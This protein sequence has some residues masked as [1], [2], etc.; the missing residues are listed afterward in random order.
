MVNCPVCGM[1][2]VQG[3]PEDEKA[4]R[5]YHDPI[6]NGKPGRPIKSDKVVWKGLGDRITVVTGHSP[7]PQRR[8]AEKAGQVANAEMHYDRGIY[9]AT[10]PPDDRDIHLFLYYV[11]NRIVGLAIFER[12]RHVWLDTWSKVAEPQPKKLDD[13]SGIWSVGFIW[14]HVKHRRRGIAWR[15]FEEGI[16][17][18][19]V[20]RSSVGFY[21]PF[22]EDGK[23]FVRSLCPLEFLIAK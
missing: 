13:C 8:R 1:A 3:L 20:D 15:L 22:S 14:V 6:A 11:R 12:R 21:T 10:E 9:C 17:H 19:G 16:A 2:Y 23:A 4:H 18:L 7:L 5:D